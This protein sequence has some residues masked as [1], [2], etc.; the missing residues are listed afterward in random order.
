MSFEEIL[1]LESA[2]FPSNDA[3]VENEE[4]RRNLN[5]K[6]ILQEKRGRHEGIRRS[7]SSRSQKAKVSCLWINRD[8]S[9]VFP[10]GISSR[11]NPLGDPEACSLYQLS[12]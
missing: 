2:A 7:K 12:S 9:C 6:K 1:G 11:S 4:E 8:R 5:S 10:L 3:N